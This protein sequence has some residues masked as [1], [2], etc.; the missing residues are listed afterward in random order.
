METTVVRIPTDPKSA[1][2]VLAVAEARAVA[3]EHGFVVLE[4][5][6]DGDRAYL[7]RQ[8]D[9]WHI[10]VATLLDPPAWASKV[11]AMILRNGE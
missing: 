7:T 11:R 10:E 3:L 8:P 5:I 4:S 2:F 6:K 1:A 9:G